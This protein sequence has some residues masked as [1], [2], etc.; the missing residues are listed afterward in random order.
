MAGKELPIGRQ[1]RYYVHPKNKPTN[2]WLAPR[3]EESGDQV[4]S[5]GKT[6][7]M[8]TTRDHNLIAYTQSSRREEAY[9]DFLVFIQEGKDGKIYPWPYDA[10]H[11]G[12]G[13]KRKEKKA[14]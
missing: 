7:F 1:Y 8:F 10:A 5:D 9:L 11:P 12:R 14:A 13:P 6:L 4:C 2:D 3:F